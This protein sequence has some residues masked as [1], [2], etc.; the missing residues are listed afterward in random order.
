MAKINRLHRVL[1]PFPAAH[2]NGN[3]HERVEIFLGKYYLCSIALKSAYALATLFVFVYP[4]ISFLIPEP[5]YETWYVYHGSW[6]YLNGLPHKSLPQDCMYIPWLSFQGNGTVK[7]IPPFGARQ[8]FRKHVPATMTT[9]SSRIVGPVVL[10]AVRVLLKESVGLPIVVRQQLGK[11]VLAAA[12]NCWCRFL[13][14][15][16]RIKWK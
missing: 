1:R 7:C 15:P 4:P 9:R 10:Y 11:D 14:G 2:G 8:R 12:K 5:I 3:V 6:V 13:C 16:C